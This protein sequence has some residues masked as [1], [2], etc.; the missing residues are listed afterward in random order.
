MRNNQKQRR[1]AYPVK[2]D[3]M[4]LNYQSFCGKIR[5]NYGEINKF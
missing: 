5:R 3:E 1:A 4:D 2:E